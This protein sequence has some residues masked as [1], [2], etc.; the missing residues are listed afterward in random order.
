M[1][2]NERFAEASMMDGK[3]A[4]DANASQETTEKNPLS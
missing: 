2:I 3:A 4:K 1:K